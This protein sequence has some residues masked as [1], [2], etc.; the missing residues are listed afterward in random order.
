[1]V[2]AEAAEEE[3]AAAKEA[4]QA[5][6]A[7]AAVAAAAAAKKTSQPATPLPPPPP[8]A[9]VD[10]TQPFATPRKL[11]SPRPLD[12][13][14]SPPLAPLGSGRA[15]EGDSEFSLDAGPA[16]PPPQKGRARSREG[17]PPSVPGHVR[18]RGE[19]SSAFSLGVAERQLSMGV[20]GMSLAEQAEAEKRDSVPAAAPPAF[21][22]LVKRSTRFMTS[23][24]V[25][26]KRT[27][28]RGVLS[29]G[30]VSRRAARWLGSKFL[31]GDG[32]GV[33]RACMRAKGLLVD[34]VL[35]LG[36]GAM[37]QETAV[38]LT[39]WL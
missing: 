21:H 20:A 1:M 25:A 11:R 3:V 24:E 14:S 17:L 6:I 9:P 10:A 29:P 15:L 2:A 34:R 35:L 5:A 19:S 28:G 39:V 32:R 27:L 12:V 38:S 31:L 4:K 16:P 36:L 8:L 18:P 30:V 22:D 13:F 26:A 23:G 33:L 37:S 7:A